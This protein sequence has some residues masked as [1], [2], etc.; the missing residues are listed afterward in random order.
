MWGHHCWSPTFPPEW[1]RGS[2]RRMGPGHRWICQSPPP[3]Q[4]PS[5]CRPRTPRH[6]LSRTSRSGARPPSRWSPSRWWKMWVRACGQPSA[7]W[8]NRGRL[9]SWGDDCLGTVAKME[10]RWGNM[11]V[12]QAA[13][14]QTA[15]N[16]TQLQKSIK[17]N[18]VSI[19]KIRRIHFMR[20]RYHKCVKAVHENLT[21]TWQNETLL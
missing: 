4:R 11:R 1:T 19:Q 9:G 14:A 10:D 5:W 2:G 17:I 12:K 20:S 21:I 8:H 15:D 7:H 16:V 13:A 3:C 6:R 18:R